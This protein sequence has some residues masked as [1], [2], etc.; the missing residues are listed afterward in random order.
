MSRL[1][2]SD[3]LHQ[4]KVESARLE[5][6]DPDLLDFEVAHI[7]GWTVGAVVGHT[8]WVY[9]YVTEVLASPDEPPRRSSIP[10]PPAGPSVLGW[11]S[12][13]A[14]A[15]IE[16]L[17]STPTDKPCASFVGPVD[18]AWWNRRLAHETAMHRWDAFASVGSVDPIEFRLASDG[19]SEVFEV[20][21]D[22]RL[23][24][25]R[26]N[27]NGETIHLHATDGQDGEWMLRLQPD[28]I[29]VTREHA[30]AD[31]AARGSTSD[32]LLMLWGRIPPAQLE[33]FGDSTILDR[34]QDAATF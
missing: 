2:T 33:L 11:F 10:E 25:D 16:Q 27:A 12:D 4:I 17:E 28:H 3:Y 6:L 24:F 20:F 22:S 29:A 1:N 13:A 8:G 30:K 26:L 15:L 23:Q 5:E 21:V 7:N 18:A 14:D 19:I 9:R 32:L 34:W 31:V